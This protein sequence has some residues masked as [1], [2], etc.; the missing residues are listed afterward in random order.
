MLADKK[1]RATQPLL[2][3]IDLYTSTQR[4]F[5]EDWKEERRI[6]R[7]H[8]Y[9]SLGDFVLGKQMAG[10]RELLLQKRRL[11]RGRSDKVCCSEAGRLSFPR[12]KCAR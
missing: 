1:P 8:D 3:C 6:K 9:V 10:K 11:E 2:Q 12:F 7:T 5:R 4:A